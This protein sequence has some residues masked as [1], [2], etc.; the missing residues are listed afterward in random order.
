[1]WFIPKQPCEVW[2]APFVQLR[3]LRLTGV[4]GSSEV[5]TQVLTSKLLLGT[6]SQHF[7]LESMRWKYCLEWVS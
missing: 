1:M 5:Y 3:N 6:A 2:H 7:L 4:N